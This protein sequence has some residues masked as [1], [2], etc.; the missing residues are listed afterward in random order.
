[1]TLTRNEWLFKI[2]NALFFVWN[3]FNAFRSACQFEKAFIET[4]DVFSLWAFGIMFLFY[5]ASAMLMLYFFWRVGRPNTEIELIVTRTRLQI[6]ES[7]N[8]MLRRM[9]N[10]VHARLENKQGAVKREAKLQE[11]KF[12]PHTNDRLVGVE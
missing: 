12:Q 11:E 10:E 9:V 1:M 4:Q 5:C 8:E 2:W 3:G 6:M 7:E